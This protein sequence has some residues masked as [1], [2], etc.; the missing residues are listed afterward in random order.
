MYHLKIKLP[1]V[2]ILP[3]LTHCLWH[4]M[5]TAKPFS[6][7]LGLEADCT[8]FGFVLFYQVPLWNSD[9]FWRTLWTLISYALIGMNVSCCE[10]V[11]QKSRDSVQNEIH[12]YAIL[13]MYYVN[14]SKDLSGSCSS[15]PPE[16]QKQRQDF[17]REGEVTWKE[18]G[19]GSKMTWAFWS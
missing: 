13:S 10:R 15:F 17:S 12:L 11:L 3:D 19:V 7:C 2:Y 1:C 4:C 9:K 6:E 18:N 5:G 8:V 14:K 16:S